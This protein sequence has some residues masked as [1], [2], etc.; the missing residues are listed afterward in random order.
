MLSMNELQTQL[1]FLVWAGMKKQKLSQKKLADQAEC[2]E[3]HL[4]DLLRGKR[5][6]TLGLWNRLLVAAKVPGF[7]GISAK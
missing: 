5:Q 1:V 4:S 2:S 3:Q 7:Q 6:G